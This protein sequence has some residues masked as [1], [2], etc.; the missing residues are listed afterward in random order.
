M[1]KKTTRLVGVSLAFC[2]LAC[3]ISFGVLAGMNGFLVISGGMDSSVYAD[4]DALPHRTNTPD[5]FANPTALDFRT[6]LPAVYADPYILH[7]RIVTQD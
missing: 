1:N 2:I 6:N 5:V 3:A 7:F 4:P